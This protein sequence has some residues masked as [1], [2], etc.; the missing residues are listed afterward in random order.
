MCKAIFLVENGTNFSKLENKIKEFPRH[1]IYS[2][3]YE[4][5]KLLKEKKI[6]H[7]V[8]EDELTSVDFDAI[9][10]NHFDSSI[11]ALSGLSEYP[12]SIAQ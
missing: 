9:L 1:T 6:A 4:S 11:P 3:D 10:S 5:H 2:L 7:K 8:G 12:Y